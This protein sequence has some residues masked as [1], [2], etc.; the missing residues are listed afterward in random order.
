ML[1]TLLDIS[2]GKRIEN[3]DSFVSALEA[4]VFELIARNVAGP[5]R[6][7]ARKAYK[8]GLVLGLYGSG[9]VVANYAASSR[10]AYGHAAEQQLL[11]KIHTAGV[12]HGLS[13]RQY[14]T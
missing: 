10:P 4:I 8:D 9:S 6:V 13:I 5:T 3:V 12:E 7:E 11:I 1:S 14:L 2:S